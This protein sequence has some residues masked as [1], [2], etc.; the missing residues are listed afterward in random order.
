MPNPFLLINPSSP[1]M[2]AYMR[3]NPN[4]P[5]TLAWQKKT[6]ATPNN[7]LAGSNNTPG[8]S[9]SPTTVSQPTAR[10]GQ[11][12]LGNPI[13]G[14]NGVNNG[15]V[16]SGS[17]NN[18]TTMP[19]SID[20]SMPNTPGQ[21]DNPLMGGTI[22]SFK[23]GGMISPGGVPIRPGAPMPTNEPAL[24]APNGQPIPSEEIDRNAQQFV[25]QNPQEVQKIQQVISYAMQ[26]G[27][28]TIDELN[29]AVQLAKTAL[30]TPAA[31]PQIR[32]FAIKNGLGTEAD[33]P[34]QMD[35]GLLYILIVAGKTM[36]AGGTRQNA[37]GVGDAM[38]G[39]TPAA[40]MQQAGIVPKYENGGMTGDKAHLAQ[41]DPHEYVI[42]KE[43]LMYHGKKTFD[44]LVEQ[45]RNPD[46]N[47]VN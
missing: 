4:S 16:R 38:M 20:T 21:Q 29:M 32:Q 7:D 41:L 47:K 22:P 15:I 8:T 25:Q 31:Y 30:S 2:A 18:N 23:E 19:G 28:L 12:I 40:N 35:Q 43:A 1:Q 10:F 26:T 14:L 39:E 24:G 6:G 46:G 3:A 27:E 33:I 11:T 45:A 34:Q 36:A 13:F 9:L 37:S 44:K 17:F 5:L 42:P